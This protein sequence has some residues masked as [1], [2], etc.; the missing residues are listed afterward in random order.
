MESADANR[1]HPNCGKCG[2][3]RTFLG[4]GMF[5]SGTREAIDRGLERGLFAMHCRLPTIDF[6]WYCAT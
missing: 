6:L 3:P 4:E 1:C 2:G 5:G